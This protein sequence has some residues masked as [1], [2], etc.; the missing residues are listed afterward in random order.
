[1]G[2]RGRVVVGGLETVWLLVGGAL[3]GDGHIPTVTCTLATPR[4]CECECRVHPRQSV[5]AARGIALMSQPPTHHSIIVYGRLMDERV[6]GTLPPLPR[7]AAGSRYAVAPPRLSVA[8]E[9]VVVVLDV[10][11]DDESAVVSST[12]TVALV[13]GHHEAAMDDESNGTDSGGLHWR[14]LP[15]EEGGRRQC[16]IV[17]LVHSACLVVAVVEGGTGAV[18]WSRWTRRW[19]PF[20]VVDSKGEALNA[21]RGIAYSGHG[22]V[23]H[24]WTG[25]ACVV[26]H[27]CRLT[28]LA[29]PL[30]LPH[31]ARRLFYARCA[32]WPVAAL[33]GAHTISSGLARSGTRCRA[34]GLGRRVRFHCICECI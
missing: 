33:D 22:S 26:S 29:M 12:H 4:E 18:V 27:S 15:V 20:K 24:A 34:C 3:L 28:L 10:V 7:P 9:S 17:S 2:R 14:V 30:L 13:C 1:M 21:I 25:I 8:E 6:C 23:V 19:S 32:H 5:R 11:A 31:S 16:R